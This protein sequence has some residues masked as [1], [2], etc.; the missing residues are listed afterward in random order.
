MYI[1]GIPAHIVQ[2]GN[3]RDVCFFSDADY[4]YYKVLLAEGL[5]RYEGHLYVY[6]LMTNHVHLPITFCY[7]DSIS[8][9]IQY[10]GRNIR[11]I[12]IR[13]TDAVPRCGRACT[14]VA[15]WMLS[16]ICYSAT[17]I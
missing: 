16:T 17:A 1:P 2:R 7:A 15:Q 4:Q 9:T 5:K 11:N 12:S 8:R 13:L 3:N 6:C 10:I 14:R